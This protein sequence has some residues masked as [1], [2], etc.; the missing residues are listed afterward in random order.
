MEFDLRLSLSITSDIAALKHR[1]PVKASSDM[2][3]SVWSCALVRPRAQSKSSAHLT[4][5]C[6]VMLG[7]GLT[8][9]QRADASPA[10]PDRPISKVLKKI[11]YKGARIE[12][13]SVARGFSKRSLF[14]M[15][16]WRAWGSLP[17]E[18][19][20][21]W[22][23]FFWP[24]V[25][26]IDTIHYVPGDER[27]PGFFDKECGRPAQ[28]V[29]KSDQ[30]TRTFALE[31][32]RGHQYVIFDPPLVTRSLKMTVKEVR[33]ESKSGGV[34]LAAISFYAHRDPLRSIKDLGA[35]AEEAIK[36]L[37]RPL[38]HTDAKAE[39]AKIGPAVA[40]LILTK[41]KASRGTPQ[42]TLLEVAPD[43]LSGLDL[44]ELRE[45][46]G[47]ISK[48]NLGLFIRVKASLGDE[49][50]TEEL[51]AHVGDLKPDE[52]ANILRS[53][54]RAREPE[55]LQFL[56]SKYGKHPEV[57]EVLRAHL[58]YFP[59]AYQAALELYEAASGQRKSA[60]LELLAKTNPKRAF[61]IVR[62]ALMQRE[63]PLL[64][65]GAIRGAAYVRKRAFKV[66]VRQ[67][68]TSVYVIERRAVAFTLA[69]WGEEADTEL[70]RDLAGDKAMSVRKEALFGLG[71]LTDSGDF[72][73]NYA[74][75]GS[76]ES[77]AEAAAKAWLSGEA[78]LDIKAPLR[79][80]SS[81]FES[82]RAHAL[83][84]LSDHQGE[85][86]E[87][88]VSEILRVD[89]IY[90]EHIGIIKKLWR[91]CATTFVKTALAS[92][93]V[94]RLRA[95]SMVRALNQPELQE[96]VT[97]IAPTD[98]PELQVAVAEASSVLTLT[99]AEF[100]L[101]SY[102]KSELITTRCSAMRALSDKQSKLTLSVIKE[103]IKAGLKDPYLADR[104]LLL[105]ALDA[106]GA[107]RSGHFAPLLAKAYHSWS[108][109]LGFVSYRLRAVKSL[110]K[111][112]ASATRLEVLLKASTDLDR[113]VRR[114]AL[115]GLRKR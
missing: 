36:Q 90:T 72:L 69:H 65:S 92:S 75:F 47:Y 107:H 8:L 49:G 35:R 17:E 62:A 14:R 80:L 93:S 66:Q 76:D 67:L 44:G 101:N 74:L 83:I 38:M 91:E 48:D 28:V 13:S 115:Q 21:A 54:A 10:D 11:P 23:Q 33:G 30:E 110:V 96:L 85:A 39:L 104:A 106:A 112:P 53:V 94:G 100:A 71:R 58:P 31:D 50:A 12:A 32:V 16:A 114:I 108:K 51:I 86:C 102:L 46:S 89:P 64:R 18:R 25:Y 42:R 113:T 3:C 103:S 4:L 20:G 77:T 97:K 19:R 63:D 81:P 57:D 82:V 95:L 73:K 87:P 45:A 111:L 105:C 41:I 1:E 70:L 99:Q 9:I 2:R 7:L 15:K 52:Q 56:L 26:Y 79:L 22:L 60:L 98:D 55:R 84:A 40:P 5:V 34:C 61:K 59:G 88:L 29:F 37:D 6:A 43:L 27:A 78:R 109:S 68:A 24:K